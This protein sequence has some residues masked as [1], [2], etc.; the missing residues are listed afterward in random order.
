MNDTKFEERQ[1]RLKRSYAESLAR[2]EKSLNDFLQSA[3]PTSPCPSHPDVVLEIDLDATRKR[4]EPAK[5]R[6]V[7]KACPACHEDR[8]R[9]RLIAMGVPKVLASATLDNWAPAGEQ[10]EAIAEEVRKFATQV[11]RGFLILL[12]PVGTGKSHLAVGAMRHWQQGRFITQSELLR[13][14]RRSYGDRS[15]GDPVE[16]C[17][18]ASVFVLDDV[19]LSTG[20]RDELPLLHDILVHRHGAK[21]PTVIT[22]NLSDHEFRKIIGE[23]A[24]DRMREGLFALLTLDG[25][26][27][28]WQHRTNYFQD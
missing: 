23:R 9:S 7:Y 14:L 25:A 20:G 27:Q 2:F 1:Q 12:G 28:R 5:P 18:S 10:D 15:E 26:S 22:S 24:A 3:A 21:L 11:R 13:W 8:E 4:F 16:E 19:G 17:Q 6:A